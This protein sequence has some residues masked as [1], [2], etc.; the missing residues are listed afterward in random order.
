[1]RFIYT[2]F[3]SKGLPVKD[4]IV[5]TDKMAAE[6]RLTGKGLTIES[7]KRD[8][9][10][11]MMEILRSSVSGVSIKDKIVFT[12]NMAVMVK[13]G[14][15]LD[16]A[17][18]ILAEQSTSPRL[19][20]VLGKINDDVQAGKTLAESMGGF[21][22]IFDR[23][24]LSIISASE[25]SGTLEQSLKYLADQQNQAY[26]IRVKIRNALFYPAVVITATFSVMLLLSIFVLPKIT[27]LFV[28]FKTELPLTTQLVIRFSDFLTDHTFGVLVALAIVVIIMPFFLQLNSVRPLT[29]RLLLRLPI[30]RKFTLYFNIALFCR[31]LG[32]LLISGVPINQAIAICSDTMRN[33][34]YARALHRVAEAQTT[35]ETLGNLLRQYPHLFS[36]MVYRMVAVGEESG[37][38]E[39]VLIFLAD[40]HEREID[41]TAKNLTNILEPLLL[42][43]IGIAVA[44]IALAIITPIYQITGSFQ[45]R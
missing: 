29:H 16:Q 7:I 6:K 1:M 42:I 26:E 15:T 9:F 28:S 5:A 25:K 13:S 19:A 23:L 33:L 36:P 32:T 10:G 17:L 39:D 31:T 34:T 12:R 2:A 24:Y 43:V 3:T 40:F 30:V 41:Y 44:V 22:H 45:F 4:V 27:A 35:G 20:R 38:L 8:R 21:P 14:L 37:N 11:T 18:S